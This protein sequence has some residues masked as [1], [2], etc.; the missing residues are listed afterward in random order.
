MGASL[1]VVLAALIACKDKEKEE[2][3]APAETGETGE[4]GEIEETEPTQEELYAQ[5]VNETETYVGDLS[6]WDG[7]SW[8]SE[9][10]DPECQTERTGGVATVEEFASGDATANATVS[11]FH[12]D[13]VAGSADATATTDENG[14]FEPTVPLCQALTYQVSDGFTEYHDT[15]E[16]HVFWDA[17]DEELSLISVSNDTWLTL[18]SVFGVVIDETLGVLAGTVRDCNGDIVENAQVLLRD[19]D[20]DIP[21]EMS[22]GY[23]FNGIPSR[24]AIS[25]TADGVWIAMNVPPGDYTVEF[26]VADGAGG[27]M[28]AGQAPA[29]SFASSVSIVVLY[30]GRGDGLDV[31]SACLDCSA[32]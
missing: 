15:Y 19:A 23:T 13:T 11:F 20:G 30:G 25:T 2:T 3:G 4:T 31:P 18:P 22:I 21:S 24:S 9:T 26:Y 32:E 7:S 27:N 14:Q 12:A 6:C 1:W 5:W 29:Q 10:V 8:V 28:L 17:G 16:Y